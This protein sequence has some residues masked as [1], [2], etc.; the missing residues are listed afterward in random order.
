MGFGN[1]VEEGSFGVPF[2]L[3]NRLHRCLRWIRI[4][5]TTRNQPS[6]KALF[7]YDAILQQNCT[8]SDFL[9]RLCFQDIQFTRISSIDADLR[10]GT[11]VIETEL[12][13]LRRPR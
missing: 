6:F 5:A 11:I 7:N 10:L 12:A 13:P 4:C 9:N 8:E 1:H 2:C 3:A